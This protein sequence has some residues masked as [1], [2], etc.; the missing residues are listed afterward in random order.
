MK[1]EFIGVENGRSNII[2]QATEL[3]R[4]LNGFHPSYLQQLDYENAFKALMILG[5]NY[6][7]KNHCVA[8]PCPSSCC[9][10]FPLLLIA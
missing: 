10:N 1:E 4:L 5:N 8:M 9:N 6:K 3:L 2:N 7:K